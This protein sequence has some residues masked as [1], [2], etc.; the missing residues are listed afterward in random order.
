MQIFFLQAKESYRGSLEILD[1]PFGSSA[2]I[3][4]IIQARSLVGIAL[5]L[6]TTSG[7]VLAFF[8]MSFMTS[9]KSCPA[10]HFHQCTAWIQFSVPQIEYPLGGSSKKGSNVYFLLIDAM[11]LQCTILTSD[12]TIMTSGHHGSIRTTFI[13]KQ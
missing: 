11:V 3:S 12:C 9:T 6:S 8:S 7:N 10:K 13:S 5:P 1:L 2:W 4:M